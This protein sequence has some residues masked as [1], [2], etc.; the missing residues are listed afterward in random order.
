[1]AKYSVKLNLT[2]EDKKKLGW[3]EKNQI[4]KMS[5]KERIKKLVEFFEKEKAMGKFTITIDPLQSISNSPCN[6]QCPKCGSGNVSRQYYAKGD[7]YDLHKSFSFKLLD[8]FERPLG[9]LEYVAKA[10]CI[11][12]HCRVCQYQWITPPMGNK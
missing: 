1:M 7:K 4:P 5:E 8:S 12:H 6:L 11:E 10:D 2:K 9:L 3:K